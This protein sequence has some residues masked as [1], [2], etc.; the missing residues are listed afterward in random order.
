M[1]KKRIFLYTEPAR[2]LS[3]SKR[4]ERF[5]GPQGGWGLMQGRRVEHNIDVRSTKQIFSRF[6]NDGNEADPPVFG[7]AVPI[8]ET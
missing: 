1:I 4:M 6:R 5:E 2:L 7:R 3:N 8:V